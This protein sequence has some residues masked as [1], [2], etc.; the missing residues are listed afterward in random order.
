MNSDVPSSAL[1]NCLSPKR[2]D[3]SRLS[4]PV[5]RTP[6]H[7][8][9]CS[10]SCHAGSFSACQ[11]NEPSSAGT[12]LS[13]PHSFPKAERSACQLH[14]EEKHCQFGK[15]KK[16]NNLPVECIHPYNRGWRGRRTQVLK[17]TKTQWCQSTQSMAQDKYHRYSSSIGPSLSS[18]IW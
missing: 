1:S 16:H 13:F 6:P 8:R 3:L 11:E 18:T 10:S 5:S 2:S 9:S 14:L 4:H 7:S 12:R 17:K 15:G